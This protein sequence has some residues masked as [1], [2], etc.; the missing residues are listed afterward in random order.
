MARRS[1][2]LR[3]VTADIDA[4]W[5]L[6]EHRR[7]HEV[8]L[9][10]RFAGHR[11]RQRHR[12]DFVFPRGHH[13]LEECRVLARRQERQPEGGYEHASPLVDQAGVACLPYLHCLL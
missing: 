1:E 2:R 10:Q 12:L 8:L 13:F 5:H 6:L 3:G 7:R 9:S 11:Q 4:P